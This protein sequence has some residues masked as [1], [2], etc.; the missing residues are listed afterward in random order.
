MQGVVKLDHRR[1]VVIQDPCHSLPEDLNQT[2]AA[3][4]SVP[5]WY[6]YN[7]LPVAVL[8]DVTFTEI[9]LDQANENLPFRGVWTILPSSLPQPVPKILCLHARRDTSPVQV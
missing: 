4:V 6:Q 7:V 3:E 2:N 9:C 8:C 1:E 5:L